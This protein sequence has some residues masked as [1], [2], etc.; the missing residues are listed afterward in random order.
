MCEAVK[1]SLELRNSWL[2]FYVL[3]IYIIKFWITKRLS[4]PVFKHYHEETFTELC[5]TISFSLSLS[6][7]EYLVILQHLNPNADLYTTS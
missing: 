6:L 5:R 2:R 3:Q 7:T 4:G 1:K